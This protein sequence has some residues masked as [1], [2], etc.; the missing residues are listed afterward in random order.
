MRKEFLLPEEDMDYLEGY[1]GNWETIIVNSQRW[2][3]LEDYPVL[4]GYN[5]ENVKLA[6]RIDSGYPNSQIDMVYF[7][8]HLSRTDNKSIGALTNQP[9]DNII[10]QRWSRHR[11]S[12]NPWRP[13]F[14]NLESHLMLVNNWLERE[15]N[16]R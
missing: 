1:H 7:F 13:G 14:D 3:I 5:V 4:D 16:I 15:F 10:F 9:L 11:T 2:L 12:Q 8:P 6:L